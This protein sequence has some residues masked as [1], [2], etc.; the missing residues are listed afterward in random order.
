MAKASF[1]QDLLWRIEAGAYDLLEWLARSFP[2]D[3]VS[4]FGSGLFRRLGPLTSSHRVAAINLKIAF[5]QASDAE[6]AVLLDAQWDQLGRWAAEFPI[7]DRII[8]DPERV[9]IEGA[10]RLKEIAESGRP[11]VFISGHFSSFELMPAVILQAGIPC[12]ITYRATNNPYVDQ[13]IRRA[14]FR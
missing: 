4:D 5:P 1:G 12:Q 2:L 7:L 6:I 9:E 14:R 13:R 8:A 3:A 11:V 10:E